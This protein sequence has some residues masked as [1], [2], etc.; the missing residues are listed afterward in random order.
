[1]QLGLQHKGTA[2][3]VEGSARWMY[4]FPLAGDEWASWK[5]RPFPG[6]PKPCFLAAGGPPVYKLSPQSPSHCRLFC[7]YPKVAPKGDEDVHWI[8]TEPSQ[9]RWANELS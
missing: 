8:L 4:P 5:G 7:E 1:M 3:A 6:A 2:S 9:P